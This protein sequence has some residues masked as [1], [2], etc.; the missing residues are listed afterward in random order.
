MFKKLM[1]AQKAHNEKFD[2]KRSGNKESLGNTTRYEFRS[3]GKFDIEINNNLISITNKGAMNF[4]TKGSVGSKTIK[5]ENIS[6]VQLKS[7]GALTGYLQFI[8]IGS[9]ESKGGALNAVKDENTI[10]FSTKME[11]GWAKEIKNYID[12]YSPVMKTENKSSADEILK[13]KQL[14]DIGALTEEEFE[15]KKKE[16]LNLNI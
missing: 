1:Q 14:L 4:M 2:I 8:I 12:S 3:N 9:Q 15:L 16:L 5:I 6:G 13:Y 11:E 10:T 7:P